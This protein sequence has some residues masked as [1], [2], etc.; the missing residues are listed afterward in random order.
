MH[1]NARLKQAAGV[2]LAIGGAAWYLPGSP[3]NTLITPYSGVTNLESV[4]IGVQSVAG[5]LLL[6]VGV[7][8]AWMGRDQVEVERRMADRQRGDAGQSPD[9][10]FVCSDCGAMFETEEAYNDHVQDSGG[11]DEEPAE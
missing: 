5:V 2:V 10:V 11:A 1:R 8:L 7:V 4:L 3:L 9:A 6:L